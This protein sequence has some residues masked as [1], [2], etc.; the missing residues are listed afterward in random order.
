[1]ARRAPIGKRNEANPCEPPDVRATGAGVAVLGR[2]GP[3]E[4]T[5]LAPDA[6]GLEVDVELGG[7]PL[8]PVDVPPPVEP[9]VDPDPEVEPEPEEE[10][11]DGAGAAEACSV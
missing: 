10:P 5:G 7:A 2:L 9:D 4:V 6:G 3:G 1:M 11:E 8:V